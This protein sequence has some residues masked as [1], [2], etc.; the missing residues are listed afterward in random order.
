[1]AD[2]LGAQLTQQPKPALSA[3]PEY[4]EIKSHYEELRKEFD[5]LK[6]RHAVMHRRVLEL[7]DKVRVKQALQHILQL[8]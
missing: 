1:M 3:A 8:K 2:T 6:K 7:E 4:E 5:D